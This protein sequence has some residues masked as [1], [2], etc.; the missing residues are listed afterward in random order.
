MGCG[1]IAC[2]SKACGYIVCGYIG[3]GSIGPVGVSL[4]N[5]VMVIGSYNIL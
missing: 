3:Y 2:G 5:R 1:S 4:D